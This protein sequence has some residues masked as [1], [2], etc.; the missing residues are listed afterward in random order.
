MAPTRFLPLLLALPAFG[1]SP[2]GAWDKHSRPPTPLEAP[3]LDASATFTKVGDLIQAQ[4]KLEPPTAAELES[5]EKLV[6]WAEACQEVYRRLAASNIRAQRELNRFMAQLKEDGAAEQ[7]L[8]RPELASLRPLMKAPELKASMDRYNQVVLPLVDKRKEGL[9]DREEWLRKS[10]SFIRESTQSTL[11]DTGRM[12]ETSK[13]PLLSGT[14]T[15]EPARIRERIQASAA[16]WADLSRALTES[17]SRW[18]ALEA[19]AGRKVPGNAFELA[20]RVR[21]RA[22][23]DLLLAVARYHL[24]LFT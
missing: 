9:K 24:V 16:V 19:E 1:Q 11:N 15:P 20:A 12:G 14:F 10:Q 21:L 7:D 2:L 5:N 17:R 18:L 13:V 6:K 3:A 4:E 23:L 22:E 8:K